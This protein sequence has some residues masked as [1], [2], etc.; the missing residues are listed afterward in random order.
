MKFICLQENLNSALNL[1]SHL[2]E[3][4]K[5]NLPILGNLLIQAKKGFLEISSTN[6][7]IAIKTK[8][9]AKIEEAGEITLPAQIFSNYISSLKKGNIT[10]KS[11][12]SNILISGEG[13]QAK[14][15]G[16]PAE[17]FPVIPQVEV[18]N[19]YKVKSNILRESLEKVLF[20]ISPLEN[21]VEISGGL[22]VFNSPQEGKFTLVG[23]NSYSL[24]EKISSL[25]SGEKGVFKNII[26]YQTLSQVLKITGFEEQEIEINTSENQISFVSPSVEIISGII[27]ANFPD[28]K[29]IIPKKYKT[30]VVLKRNE[31]LDNL[32]SVSLFSERNINDISFEIKKDKLKIASSSN[33]GES[34]SQVKAD[35]EGQ[36]NN[37]I[38]NSKYLMDFLAANKEEEIIMEII[39]DNE[40]AVF[41]LKDN[42]DYLYLLMPIKT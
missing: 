4:S 30:R 36:N 14:M 34:Y 31:L 5:N 2:T 33:I 21:R 18:K 24:A 38:L 22:L 20:T 16:S 29:E 9:R 27:P 8:V 1:V 7:E 32:R 23:T 10:F 12:K 25:N 37:I 19:K 6:L 11:E 3:K 26:P 42:A 13:S 41:R 17:D 39:D 15:I 28:Y 40:P 35:I